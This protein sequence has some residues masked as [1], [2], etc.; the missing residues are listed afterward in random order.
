[1]GKKLFKFGKD[2][3]PVINAN[4]AAAR[5]QERMRDL[6]KRDYS[7]QHVELLKQL[8]DENEGAARYEEGGAVALQEMVAPPTDLLKML[9]EQT[10]LPIVNIGTYPRAS[11]KLRRVIT[12]EQAKMLKVV[13]LEEREDG[14][15]LFAIADPSN[16]TILDTLRLTLGADVEAAI[17]DEKDIMDRIEQY[18]GMDGESIEQI[19]EDANVEEESDEDILTGD[20]A[21]IDLTDSSTNTE[22]API[23]RLVNILLAKAISDRASDIHIE[24][25]PTFIRVRYRV[26]GVLREIPAPPR[27]QLVPIVS[28]LK[29]MAGMN[30]S[31]TRMPQDGR[32]KL[33]LE[34]RE[35]DMR[36]SSVPT[37]HGEAIVMRVL[38]KSMMNVGISHIG[39]LPEVL[40]QFKKLIHL[41][42]GIILVTGPTGCGKTTTLYA[43]LAEVRDPGEKLITTEDPVEYELQGIQQVNI[44]EGIGLTYARC[45]RAILR[46]DPDRVLV[47][48]IRDVETAQIAVQAALTGHLVFSTLHTNSAA[49]TVTRL[50]DM[51]VEPF[52]ITSSL[53]GVI[54]QRLVR[55]MCQSC[56]KP[57]D[58]SEEDLYEFSKT[59]DDIQEMGLQFYMG[60][61]CNECNQTGYHGRMGIFELLTVDDDI[62]ELILERATTDEIQEVALRKGMISMRKDGWTKASIGM[63]SLAEVARQT[64]RESEM[65]PEPGAKGA[66]AEG[67]AMEPPEAIEERPK[68]EALEAP[69]EPRI[70]E[71][72]M[73]IG[74]EEAARAKDSKH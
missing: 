36:V 20:Q 2:T 60:E 19:V 30:I 14:K 25:F 11:A 66:A 38:D 31:E 57:Y 15:I 59:R 9:S 69:H 42:N 63:T 70:D 7:P 24:P 71:E 54:G 18:Y 64:P 43:A 53:E 4:E 35:I 17:A 3:A 6:I 52:L 65:G 10:G 12:P 39:M 32:I 49:A 56:R 72:T 61:G 48:E 45:L 5:S 46:Q 44:N 73:S 23:I 26:D 8:I 50:L 33:T 55:T 68:H 29:V 34:N 21:Q 74:G 22:Q 58:P 41:P 51:G 40:D 13:P 47:G 37:V 62:R 1:M 27:S 28:R 67:E 16:P